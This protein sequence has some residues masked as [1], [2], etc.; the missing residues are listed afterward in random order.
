MCSVLHQ[1]S[2]CIIN[3]EAIYHISLRCN[4]NA[5]SHYWCI[6]NNISKQLLSYISHHLALKYRLL[7]IMGVSWTKVSCFDYSRSLSFLVSPTFL[8]VCLYYSTLCLTLCYFFLDVIIRSKEKECFF[9][10]LITKYQPSVLRLESHF[11]KNSWL[12]FCSQ[13]YGSVFRRVAQ[14]FILCQLMY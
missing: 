14:C 5:I 12:I 7:F 8:S 1:D 13:I 3:T 11:L 4:A 6:V 10:F 2:N 9:V